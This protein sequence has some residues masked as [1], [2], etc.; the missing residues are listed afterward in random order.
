MFWLNYKNT[1]SLISISLN[2][3]KCDSYLSHSTKALTNLHVLARRGLEICSC[4]VFLF[5]EDTGKFEN[6]H[7]M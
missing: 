6:L 2:S 5:E 3:K 1:G 4:F 7:A